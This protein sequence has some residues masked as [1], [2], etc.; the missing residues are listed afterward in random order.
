MKMKLDWIENIEWS[1][2][3]KR[4]PIVFTSEEITRILLLMDGVA[5]LMAAVLYGAGLRLQE[6]IRLRIMDLDFGYRQI[7]IRDGK[8][9]KDRVTLLP[10]LLETHLQRQIEK[11]RII[12]TQDLGLGYG[13][14]YLP[15]AFE[16]KYSNASREFMWQNLF[17]SKQISVDPRSEH[18]RRHHVSKDFLQRTLKRAIQ[19]SGINKKGSCHTLRHSFATH[20]LESGYDI[21]TIQELH[22][23]QRT[24]STDC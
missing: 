16:R 12:H 11:I 9:Q 23:T 15:Y 17:P 14:V 3:P 8:G 19:K 1:K 6:C 5:W 18:K 2:K 4:L 10:A 21:R 7:M 13:C 22:C 20:L 24:C